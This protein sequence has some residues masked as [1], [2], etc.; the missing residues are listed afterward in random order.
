MIG[1]LLCSI[2][3]ETKKSLVDQLLQLSYLSHLLLYSYRRNFNSFLTTNLYS[4]IQSTIQD[5]FVCAAIFQ[6]KK[7]NLNLYLY[8]LGTDQ[9]ENLFST[10]TTLTHASG[11]DFL[12]LHDRIK[13]ALQ[14][15]KVF[16]YFSNIL[17]N[18][19]EK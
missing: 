7:S 19:F 4:D 5:A 2:F 13:I 16:I 8:M 11:C 1:S 12:E 3:F 10:I 9:L 17:I 6:D 14:I 18:R 15:E